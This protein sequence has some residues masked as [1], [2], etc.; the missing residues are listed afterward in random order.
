MKLSDAAVAILARA[1][2]VDAAEIARRKAFLEF[3]EADVRLLTERHQR[4]CRPS[5]F[6]DISKILPRTVFTVR[7]R[8]LL[9]LAAV[10]SSDSLPPPWPLL[11]WPYPHS[12]GRGRF[13][14]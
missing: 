10:S 13:S 1:I 3:G 12:P 8:R 5:A 6:C 9:S 11:S 7:A 4:W 2:G 14:C